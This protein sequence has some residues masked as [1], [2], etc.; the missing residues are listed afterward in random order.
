MNK[1]IEELIEKSTIR[2]NI[3]VR[4]DG[5]IDTEIFFDKE[6]FADLLL[7]DF[8]NTLEEQMRLDQVLKKEVGIDMEFDIVKNIKKFYASGFCACCGA[9][10]N[11][12]CDDSCVWGER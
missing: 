7:Q 1:R 12:L 5:T 10:N 9:P 6:F 3:D 2:K 4:G 11:T 8:C